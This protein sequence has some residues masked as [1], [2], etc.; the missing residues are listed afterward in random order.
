MS[1]RNAL[2][3]VS[4]EPGQGKASSAFMVVAARSEKQRTTKT[5]LLV[6]HRGRAPEED[7]GSSMVQ[8][9][10][11]PFEDDTVASRSWT[12][13]APPTR[14][15]QKG[16]KVSEA[17]VWHTSPGLRGSTASTDLL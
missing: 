17:K 14:P 3:V 16:R 13:D 11:K 1:V 12:P 10:G 4:E 5:K 8:F 7:G 15:S 6:K 2:A 9:D